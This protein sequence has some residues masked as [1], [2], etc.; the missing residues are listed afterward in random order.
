MSDFKAKC[1]SL[2]IYA[3]ALCPTPIAAFKGAYFKG[4][5][6]GKRGGKRKEREGRGKGK[7]VG[8]ESGKQGEWKERG[9]GTR[10]PNIL[11]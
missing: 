3:G 10:P 7:R 4:E 2:S 9:G 6:E 5:G 1:T 11:V 8:R